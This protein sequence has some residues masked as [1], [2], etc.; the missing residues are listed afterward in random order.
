MA[1]FVPL[2][3]SFVTEIIDSASFSSEGENFRFDQK[4]YS[5]STIWTLGTVFPELLFVF[6]LHAIDFIQQ[7]FI[8]DM[9]AGSSFAAVPAGSYQHV[10][11]G[12]ALGLPGGLS[13]NFEQGRL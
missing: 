12:P 3:P 1:G 4:W 13:T 6:K 10:Q 7:S 11:N 5:S 8:A 9:K 2:C